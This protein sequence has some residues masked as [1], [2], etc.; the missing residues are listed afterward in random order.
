[1]L[2]LTPGRIP[3]WLARP[4]D[5]PDPGWLQHF[6]FGALGL[7]DSFVLRLTR[8][9]AARGPVLIHDRMLVTSVVNSQPTELD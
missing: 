3:N 4:T 9:S 2:W 6:A 7:A 5:C 1:M 8:Q